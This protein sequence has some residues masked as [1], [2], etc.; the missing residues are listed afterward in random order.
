MKLIGF[1]LFTILSG[2]AYGQVNII[3][4][5]LTDSSMNIFYIGAD[6]KIRIT[7]IT[8]NYN[9]TISGGGGIL[10]KAGKG[11]Y[12]VWVLAPTDLCELVL[13]KGTRK[14]LQK[15]Y[16]VRTMADQIA[17]LSGIKDTTVSRNR[18]LLNPFLSI[19]IPNCYYQHNV[20]VVS[21][22]AAFIYENDSIPTT[23]IDNLLSQEQ[24]RLVKEAVAGSKIYFDNIR[25]LGPSDRTRKLSPFWIKIE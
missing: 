4:E 10:H 5:S 7:G 16:K 12:F 21:F 15:N 25:V 18:I 23:A 9:I 17:T 2:T 22:T 20:R 11:Q 19:V 24:L 6:N 8:D 1:S 3:N 14:I 13:L